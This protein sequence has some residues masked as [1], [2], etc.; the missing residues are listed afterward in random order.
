M[1]GDL[2]KRIYRSVGRLYYYIAYIIYIGQV[3]NKESLHV[4]STSPP[5]PSIM[6]FW[7]LPVHAFCVLTLN[8]AQ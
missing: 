1:K 5:Y 7:F 4:H 6:H 2:E 8:S 3:D